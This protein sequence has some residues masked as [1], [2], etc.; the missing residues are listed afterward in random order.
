MRLEQRMREG[1]IP[2]TVVEVVLLE[3]L[4]FIL[5]SEYMHPKQRRELTCQQGP[6]R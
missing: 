6:G 3:D 2:E 5:R 1:K 4:V